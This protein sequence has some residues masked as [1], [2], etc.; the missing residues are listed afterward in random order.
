MGEIVQGDEGPVCG[1]AQAIGCH[2]VTVS[3]QEEEE[4]VERQEE[5]G[6]RETLKEHFTWMKCGWNEK[7]SASGLEPCGVMNESDEDT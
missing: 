6:E 7:T 3:H 2:G 5:V 4:E 1:V